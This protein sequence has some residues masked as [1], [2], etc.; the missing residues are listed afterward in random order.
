LP[1]NETS[2]VRHAESVDAVADNGRLAK[3]DITQEP[4][5]LDCCQDCCHERGQLPTRG[6]EPEISAEHAAAAGRFWTVCP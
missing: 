4:Q 6:D 3:T 1:K 5:V 2:Q